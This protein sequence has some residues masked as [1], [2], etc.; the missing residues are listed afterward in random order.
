MVRALTGRFFLRRDRKEPE[1]AL[2]VL[3]LARERGVEN[4]YIRTQRRAVEAELAKRPAE[5]EPES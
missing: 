3:E 2:Q 4:E 1:L 5:V